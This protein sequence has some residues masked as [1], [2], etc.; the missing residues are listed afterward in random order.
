MVESTKTPINSIKGYTYIYTHTI[1]PYTCFNDIGI[2]VV[3]SV[4]TW[5]IHDIKQKCPTQSFP[6]R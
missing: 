2:F 1:L 5:V 4:L 3:F 6:I